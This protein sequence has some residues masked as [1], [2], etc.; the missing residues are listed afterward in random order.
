M[1]AFSIAAFVLL[2]A[3]LALVLGRGDWNSAPEAAAL[4]A[5]KGVGI[6]DFMLVVHGQKGLRTQIKEL[7]GAGGPKDDMGWNGLRARAA[8]ITFLTE[9][10]LEKAAPP[11][12]DKAAW[13]TK[14]DEYL[15]I[16]KALTKAAEDRDAAAMKIE[17]AKLTKSCEAC[18]KAHKA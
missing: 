4:A 2:A 6:N 7:L 13:K 17:D 9:T 5:E 16:A 18:H 3:F 15:K 12:G 11:K 1:R 10:I 8:V 14:V